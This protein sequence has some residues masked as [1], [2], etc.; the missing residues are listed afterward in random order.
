MIWTD[1]VYDHFRSLCQTGEVGRGQV[2]NLDVYRKMLELESILRVQW[3]SGTWLFAVWIQV[4]QLYEKVK[5][6]VFRSS[7]DCPRQVGG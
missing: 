3:E 1:S 5:K 7:R 6:L 2:D 4:P